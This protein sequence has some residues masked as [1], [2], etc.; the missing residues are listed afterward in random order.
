M[1]STLEQIKQ[2]LIDYDSKQ[3]Y[4]KHIVRTDNWYF[5]NVL[6]IPPEEIIKASDDFKMIVSEALGVSFNSVMMVGSGKIGYSLAPSKKFKSFTLNPTGENKSDI[7]IAVI[8]QPIFEKFWKEFRLGYNVANKHAYRYISREIYRGYI[9]ERN[10]N[11]VDR[12]RIIW[13][14]ISNASTRNLKQSLY[15]KHDISYRIYR[16]WE[17]FEDYN[18]ETINELK[19]EVASN[20]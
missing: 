3:F 13:R 5:E 9:N 17:D 6:N 20:A 4:M 1:S 16:S 18:I 12:C 19:M 11:E 7:D 8:S 10:I 2:D 14:D 15:F